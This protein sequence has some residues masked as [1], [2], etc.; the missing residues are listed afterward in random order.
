MTSDETSE[1]IHRSSLSKTLEEAYTDYAYYIISE[2]AIPDARDGLKPVHRRIL[3]AMHQMRLTYASS[4]KKCARIVGEVTGKYHP[5]AGGVYETLV[6]LAQPFS[7]RYPVVD[8]Q[9]NFGSIDGFPP[10]AMRYTEA[11][12]AKI[13]TEL[14]QDVIPEIVKFQENFDG[15]EMEPT[16]LPV[17]FPLL[18]VNGTSGIAVGL[19]SNMPPHNI[20][21]IVD[22]TV[23]LIDDPNTI[24]E[25]LSE[26]VKGPDFPTGGVIVNGR[27]MRLFNSTGKGPIILRAKLEVKEPTESRDEAT[28]IVHEIPYLT[29]KSNL[30]EELHDLI[31]SKKIRGLVDA[32]DLSKNKIRIEIDIHEDYSHE[33]S[34][35]VIISQLYKYSQ[36]EKTFYAKNIAFARGRPLLLNLK[37]A[38]TIFLEHR[39]HVVKKTVKHNLNKALMRLNILEGLYIALQNI[40]EV[41]ELIKK[42]DDRQAAQEKLIKRFSLNEAQAKA[43]LSMQLARLARMEV[44][45]ILNEKEE[46]EAKAEEYRDILAHKEKRMQI[47]RKELEEIKE[48]FGDERRT[49]ITDDADIPVD[50]DIYQMLHDRHLLITTTQQGYVRSIEIDK[51]RTQR[52]GGKGMTAVTLRENDSLNDIL[53]TLNKSTLLLITENGLVHSTPAFEIPEAKRR[54]ARGSPWKTVLPVDSAVVKMVP[55]ERD[56]FDKGLFLFFVTA[57]G[58]VKKTKLSAFSNVRKTGIIGIRLEAG[59]KVVNSF[60]TTGD[61]HIYLA[62]K[63]GLMA[64]FPEKEVRPMGRATR[65]VTGMRFK[66]PNDII[67][68][69]LTVPESEMK[70]SS[71]LT[72]TE[73]GF[74]KR[75][76]CD[77]Y[78][79][80]H[81]GARGVIDIKTEE[82][83]GNVASVLVVPKKPTRE[84]SVSILNNLGISIRT[85]IETIREI[86]RN[87]KGV[88]IMSTEPDERIVF[89]TIIDLS[90]EDIES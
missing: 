49:T 71:I 68:G 67:I 12:L 66:T 55:V 59:D 16:V 9:G 83:N 65:G 88:K 30:M 73:R 5:H 70:D 86:S 2:R 81:R 8:G 22:A 18:L 27:A 79:F 87:T 52:R 37:R 29:N 57:R 34:I 56:S 47:I 62:T 54:N 90:E 45:A 25:D 32:R 19:S 84:N 44:E 35:R 60:V 24:V 42:S 64:H 51:F 31:S 28:I 1:I 17:K 76:A 40:D 7:L 78:R 14:L 43:I 46:L 85:R 26:Y 10:A 53:V 75:T 36:L 38:L 39:E 3:W 63:F 48:K 74:G 82:R 21:E 80:T 69:G 4:H 6:R 58:K 11:R 13:S 20:S 61:D 41:I 15:E 89:A 33:K 77:K 72:I 23:Q 50:A